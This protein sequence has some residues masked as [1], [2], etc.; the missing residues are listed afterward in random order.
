VKIEGLPGFVPTVTPAEACA[1]AN[2]IIAA[3]CK[4]WEV[5]EQS[6]CREEG[7]R[8]EYEAD[9]AID[10]FALFVRGDTDETWVRDRLELAVACVIELIVKLEDVG[11]EDGKPL[12]VEEPGVL[13]RQ[14]AMQERHHRF[15][16]S[17]GRIV[18]GLVA[19]HFASQNSTN[20]VIRTARITSTGSAPL[21]ARLID[22]VNPL[23]TGEGN[24]A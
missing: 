13:F 11:N 16:G 18:V 4:H 19:H 12:T 21:I 7:L 14:F 20:S 9:T 1:I 8:A 10:Q 3:T 6:F 15:H 2:Q 23:V 17:L 22:S 24:C 5:I